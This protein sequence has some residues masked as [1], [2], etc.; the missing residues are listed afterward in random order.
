MVRTMTTIV[1]AV[2]IFASMS[3]TKTTDFQ[4]EPDTFIKEWLICG[5]FPNSINCQLQD[6]KH[7]ACCEGFFTDYLESMGGEANAVPKAGDKISIP[8]KR[9]NQ[10][11]FVYNSPDDKI[12][13]NSIL[14][15]NDLVVAYAFTKVISSKAQKAVLAVGSNDGL[16]V[17]LNGEKIHQ[18]HP[19]NGRWLQADNDYIPVQLKAGQNNLMLKVDEGGGDWGFIARFLDYDSTIADIRK[20]IEKHKI[21]SLVA[22]EDSLATQFGQPYKIEMLNPGG[23][24][25]IELVHEKAGIVAERIVQPGMETRFGTDNIPDG[26]ITAKATFSTPEDGTIISYARHYKGRLKRH[27]VP[28][29]VNTKNGVISIDGKPF[30]PIGTY[31]APVEDYDKLKQA[32]YNFV[33]AHVENLDKVHEAGLKAA[34]HV[35]GTPP[36]WPEVAET[37]NKYKNHPAVLCWMLFDEPGYNRADLLDIYNLYNVVYQADP[38]HLSYLVITTPTVYKTFGQCCDILSVDTYPIAQGD[39]T[40]VGRN[41]AKAY[42]ET[43]QEQPLWHCG[44]LFKWPA[45]RMPTP[46]EHRYMTYTALMEGANGLLWYTYKGFGQYLPVDAPDLWEYHKK[47]LKEITALTP[48]FLE[49]RVGKKITL[50]KN[51]ELIHGYIKEC[52]LGQ[53]AIVVNHSK[54][55]TVT[56]DIKLPVAGGSVSVYGEDRSVAV[57]GGTISDEFKPL[58][59]H[60]YQ[61]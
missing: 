55:E 48:L 38:N 44:Q 26:F 51:N 52:S 15:P 3:C 18:M 28:K 16:Q 12:S 5:P 17:F 6:Y 60:I 41:M 43:L 35:S 31:G 23:K 9:I 25:K 46:Q 57:A 36:D 1:L 4:Y 32:G 54:T 8:E 10:K 61:L 7:G 24:V 59:V 13:L 11:W 34:V 42:R 14:T 49:R 45:Q 40:A 53:F 58:D 33:V 39:I 56:A 2:I 27:P 20:N 22:F 19:R 37:V 29:M 50:A 21:L 47:L 30:F